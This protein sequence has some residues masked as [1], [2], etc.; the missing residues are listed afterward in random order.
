MK[1]K[2]EILVLAVILI[3]AATMAACGKK[4][5]EAAKGT[6]SIA[7]LIAAGKS[8]V[9][10]GSMIRGISPVAPTFMVSVTNVSDCPIKS[11]TG[12]VVYFDKDGK[13]LPDAKADTGYAELTVIKPGEKIE[14]ST[15]STDENAASGQW[16]IKEVIYLKPIPVKNLSGDIPYKWTNPN[17]EAELQAAE[18]K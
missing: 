9:V 18:N 10:M 13:Y 1:R 11:I 15:M 2:P 7:D 17:Y 4:G 14:L 5:T 3:F 12:M 16:I 6:S 8:P